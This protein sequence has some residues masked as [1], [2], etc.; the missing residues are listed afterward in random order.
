MYIH[1]QYMHIAYTV[2]CI[3]SVSKL[4]GV[5]YRDSGWVWP[6]ATETHMFLI[7]QIEWGSVSDTYQYRISFQTEITFLAVG[8]RLC[9]PSSTV[10]LL[11]RRKRRRR[12]RRGGG[13]GVT[14]EGLESGRKYID[15]YVQYIHSTCT[16]MYTYIHA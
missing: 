6:V 10:V 15:T 7:D 3:W 1:V 11:R 13:G 5:Y 9:S 16:Y 14:V 4:Y 12:K 8:G 2:R